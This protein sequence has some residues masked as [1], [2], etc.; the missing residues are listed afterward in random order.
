MLGSL[1][2]IFE[3][4]PKHLF[5]EHFQFL[6]SLGATYTFALLFVAISYYSEIKQN[7]IPNVLMYFFENFS[8]TCVPTTITY[9]LC[10]SFSYLLQIIKQNLSCYYYPVLCFVTLIL[11]VGVY[12]LYTLS[13]E[14]TWLVT[15]DIFT[16]LLLFFNLRSYENIYQEM[17]RRRGLT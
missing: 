10:E 17:H 13:D 11:Y 7:E 12:L 4:T 16:L 3:K 1:K 5:R 6:L 15:T 8:L 14:Y 9:I 2:F